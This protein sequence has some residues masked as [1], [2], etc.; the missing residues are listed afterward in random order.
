[1]SNTDQLIS[2]FL[3]EQ[4]CIKKAGS[5]DAIAIKKLALETFLESHGHSA[6]EEDVSE[7]TANKFNVE[8]I[9]LELNDPKN[10]FHI[11]YI[12]GEIAGYSKVLFN[13]PY[14]KITALNSCKFE[15]LYILEKF[16]D[17]KFGKKLMDFNLDLAKKN[18]QTSLWLY[19]WTENERAIKFYEKYNFQRIAETVFQ[20]SERHG[21]PN[22]IM[23]LKI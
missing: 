6:P 8:N 3:E 13:T 2:P 22:W 15:R 19:V 18:K 23:N 17:K 14:E 4:I 12:Q 21:N 20:I 10:I 5:E 9:L 11:L 16:H 7:Y 1:M